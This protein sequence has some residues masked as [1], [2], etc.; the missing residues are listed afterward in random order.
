MVDVFISYSRRT[1][2]LSKAR[3]SYDR[4]GKVSWFDQKKEPLVGLPP[5]SKWWDEIR[6]GIEAT[7]N[8]L[9]VISPESI[10]SSNCNAEIA[11]AL[12]HEKRIVTVL[13]CGTTGEIATLQA[14]DS[15]IDVIP[16][17]SELFPEFFSRY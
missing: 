12:Y 2:V 5:V 14:I 16:E 4:R 8:F 15:A 10:V 7:D 9:F 17:D 13:Y 1:S 11:H 6:H 3:C